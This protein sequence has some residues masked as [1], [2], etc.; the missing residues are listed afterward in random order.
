MSRKCGR[1][2]EVNNRFSLSLSPEIN[3]CITLDALG[4]LNE[5]NFP[6]HVAGI[7]NQLWIADVFISGRVEK[8][9]SEPW[10]VR[11]QR[12]IKRIWFIDE[13][14]YW[15]F[16]VLFASFLRVAKFL[17]RKSLRRHRILWRILLWRSVK[18][19]LLCVRWRTR[20][21]KTESWERFVYARFVFS[22]KE[23]TG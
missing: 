11:R 1:K 15:T 6:S 8:K 7:E 3:P 2:N 13:G 18:I 23:V 10:N 20:K 17:L 12:K 21:N 19:S 9:H 5:I 22:I 16:Y 4:S 14:T